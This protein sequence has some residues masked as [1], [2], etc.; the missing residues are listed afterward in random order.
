MGEGHGWD[1]GAPHPQIAT[2]MPVS[3][4]CGIQDSHF[5]KM[6]ISSGGSYVYLAKVC[7]YSRSKASQ[8]RST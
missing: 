8:L 4:P 6:N 7:F 5:A 3:G 1:T 2:A